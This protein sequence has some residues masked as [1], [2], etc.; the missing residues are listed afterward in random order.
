M[1]T[2]RV[3]KDKKRPFFAVFYKKRG[4][5]HPKPPKMEFLFVFVVTLHERIVIYYLRQFQA[6][7]VAFLRINDIEKRA[8]NHVCLV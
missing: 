3:Q 8:N 2:G 6:F 1:W 7:Q 5:R 4:V